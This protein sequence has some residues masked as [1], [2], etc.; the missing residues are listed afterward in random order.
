MGV[1]DI[2]Y[3]FCSGMGKGE[4]EE[5]GGGGGRFDFLLK[6]PGGWSLSEGEVPRGR[7]GVCG[8]LGIFGGGGGKYFCFSGPKCPPRQ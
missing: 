6:I 5:P 3:F 4:P 1:S 7:E 8:E 2:F